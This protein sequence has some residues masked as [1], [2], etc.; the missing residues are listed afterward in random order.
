MSLKITPQLYNNEVILNLSVPEILD[1]SNDDIEYIMR[2]YKGDIYKRRQVDAKG[3]TIRDY[4]DLMCEDDSRVKKFYNVEKKEFIYEVKSARRNSLYF[5]HGTLLTP[6]NIKQ[7]KEVIRIREL[8]SL[9]NHHKATLSKFKK[10]LSTI[11]IRTKVDYYK[12]YKIKKAIIE[13]KEYP[14]H[15]VI[16]KHIIVKQW[17]LTFKEQLVSYMQNVNSVHRNMYDTKII[18]LISQ[19]FEKRST[20][21]TEEEL[22]NKRIEEYTNHNSENY[23]DYL[24]KN[25]RE[26]YKKF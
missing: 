3:K 24:N 11:G 7:R 25:H 4:L 18:H 14:D 8:K 16:K 15:I 9:K 10:G 22:I 6:K 5:N 26:N 20:V 17:I 1:K 2:Y 12:A 23:I 21:E 19:Y 13:A